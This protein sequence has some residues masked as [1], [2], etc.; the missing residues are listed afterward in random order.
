M[1]NRGDPSLLPVS[2]AVPKLTGRSQASGEASYASTMPA[3][4]G[5]LHGCLVYATKAA[6]K[7]LAI[8]PSDALVA[9]GVVDF[10]AAADIPGTNA[11][12][13][14]HEPVFFPAGE[15]HPP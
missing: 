10:V 14:P 8:D 5:Q 6:A 7:L 11:L 2:A 3:P 12:S 15:S 13:Y 1:F 4:T 9:P